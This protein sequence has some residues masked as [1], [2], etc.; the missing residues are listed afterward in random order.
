M[1]GIGCCTRSSSQ[2]SLLN[3]DRFGAV[4]AALV[5]LSQIIVKKIDIFHM[6]L[7]LAVAVICEIIPEILSG[8]WSSGNHV[9]VIPNHI[10]KRINPGGYKICKGLEHSIYVIRHCTWDLMVFHI[11]NI[12]A[13]Y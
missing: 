2:K 3:L 10:V 12:V 8:I 1:S 11:S 4:S 6:S 9:S 13:A 7:L 5:T